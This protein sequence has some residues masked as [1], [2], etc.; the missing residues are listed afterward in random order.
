MTH[1][2]R[3]LDEHYTPTWAAEALIGS[4]PAA[5]AGGVLDPAVG[6][7][8]LLSAVEK[9]FG[10][11]V[12]LIG[13]DLSET[14][15]Q[16][17]RK[18][19]SSWLV[20]TADLL[21]APSR[22]ASRAWRT[23]RQSGLG[24]VV[25]NPPF[26]YRGNGG[27]L[28]EYGSF[29]GRVA[30]AMHFLTEVASGLTPAEGIFAIL[31]DGALDAERHEDLWEQLSATYDIARLSRLSNSSFR[32]VRVSTSI[33]RLRPKQPQAEQLPDPLPITP[34]VL[35]S[36]AAAPATCRCIEIVR[37]RVPVHSRPDLGDDKSTAPFIHTTDLNATDLKL[38]APD[39]LADT[40][41]LL[42]VSRVGKW[43]KPRVIE[44]GRVVLSDCLIGLRPKNKGS[45]DELVKAL[46]TIEGQLQKRMRGTGAPYLTLTD[47]RQVL[48]GAGWH[49]H[50]VKASQPTGLC[51]CRSDAA[52]CDAT[53]TDGTR[54]TEASSQ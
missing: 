37:G 44:L 16:R 20:S 48:E 35:H 28:V 11:S 36:T 45:L 21:S 53:S 24:A 22:S 29:R 2:S 42:L 47:V 50:V 10:D 14:A 19:H 9:R 25:M 46:P 49:V 33:V 52:R 7:G 18:T 43:R 1:V 32:G 51:C 15:V 13:L 38:S 31:P 26:S 41:P 3:R 34:L 23:A 30:P 17:L 39:R 40:A 8:A 12:S 5:L 54:R 6:G 27:S 4:L